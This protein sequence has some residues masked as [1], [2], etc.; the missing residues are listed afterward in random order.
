MEAHTKHALRAVAVIA[1][2]L[3]VFGEPV[4]FNP[5]RQVGGTNLSTVDI[6]VIVNVVDCEKS[7]STLTT[8]C[9][10]C[11][12]M[13][14]D[15]ATNIFSIAARRISSCLFVRRS[16]CRLLR[17]YSFSIL[18][19]IFGFPFQLGLFVFKTPFSK[20]GIALG[21]VFVWHREQIITP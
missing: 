5:P 10:V 9:A 18:R 21:F 14:N 1:E 12:V 2:D 15:L 8:T 16:P 13:I 17:S 11:A 3:K 20:I 6:A 4:L 19:A 7:V